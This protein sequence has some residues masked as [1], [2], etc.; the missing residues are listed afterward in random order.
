MSRWELSCLH[1]SPSQVGRATSI[2]RR[3]VTVGGGGGQQAT[4]WRPAQLCVA[5]GAACWQSS[6]DKHKQQTATAV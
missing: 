3:A 2:R 4:F 5:W 6:V 1:S